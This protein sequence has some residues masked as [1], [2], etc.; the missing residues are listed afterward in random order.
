MAQK[1][2]HTPRMRRTLLPPTTPTT[3]CS[4]RPAHELARD[5][6]SR[7]PTERSHY[8][9]R[10]HRETP[11][12]RYELRIPRVGTKSPQ[13][14]CGSAPRTSPERDAA[15]TRSRTSEDESGR[16]GKL[17]QQARGRIK[18][19]AADRATFDHAIDHALAGRRAPVNA[20]QPAFRLQLLR[21]LW[22]Y[23]LDRAIDENQVIRCARRPACSQRPDRERHPRGAHSS[24]RLLGLARQF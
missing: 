8:A 22:R 9:A 14:V 17:R 21:Q 12:S 13:V 23:D 15:A 24:E 20:G 19:R 4:R 18:D 16:S 3:P 1:Y 11:A 5:E 6:V 10:E 2:A 7:W